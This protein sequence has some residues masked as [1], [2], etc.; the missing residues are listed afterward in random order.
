MVTSALLV[1]KVFRERLFSDLNNHSTLGSMHAQP[2]PHRLISGVHPDLAGILPHCAANQ[3]AGWEGEQEIGPSAVMGLLH[4]KN[5]RAQNEGLFPKT[6]IVHPTLNTTICLVAVTKINTKLQKYASPCS[7]EA[8]FQGKG[9]QC[10]CPWMKVKISRDF[11]RVG[12]MV[13]MCPC[14]QFA[15]FRSRPTFIN[16]A[17]RSFLPPECHS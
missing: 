3:H 4:R 14:L 17:A 16:I 2:K 12:K 8:A 15:S 13:K 7:L 6:S 11:L 10:I 9:Q 1:P 5:I